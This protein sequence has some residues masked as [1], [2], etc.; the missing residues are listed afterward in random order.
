MLVEVGFWRDARDAGDTR[1]DPLAMVSAAWGAGEGGR[2]QCDRGLS[3]AADRVAAVLNGERSAAFDGETAAVLNGERSGAVGGAAAGLNAEQNAATDGATAALIT[4]R[5]TAAVPNGKTGA[6]AA[7]ATG[8][9]AVPN[10]EQSAAAGEASAV[11]DAAAAGAQAGGTEGGGHS[12]G[13]GR[14]GAVDSAVG[15]M[16]AVLEYL[17]WGYLHSYELGYSHCRFSSCPSHD[18][19]YM[20]VGSS[21][22]RSSSSSGAALSDRGDNGT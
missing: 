1:P 11:L 3:A 2:A 6:A 12:H 5:S 7:A 10:V 15:E 8:A 4:E 13:R 21:D 14:Q 17:R 20:R 22:S 16:A 18:P 9:A 19:N